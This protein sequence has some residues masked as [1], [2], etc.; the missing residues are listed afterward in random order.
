MADVPK[1]IL[2]GLGLGVGGAIAG[3]KN[4]TPSSIVQPVTS[5]LDAVTHIWDT[6]SSRAFMI[7]VAEWCI[8]ISLILVAVVHMTDSGSVGSLLKKGML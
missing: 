8:G 7:R 4:E 3:A 1:A 5:S 6:L 2:G